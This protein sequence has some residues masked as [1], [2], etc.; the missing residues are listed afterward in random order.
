MQ[1]IL[2]IL[3][4]HFTNDARVLKEAR[5]LTKAGYKV[6]IFCLWDN[7]L[8]KEETQEDIRIR[9]I[10][11][12]PQKQSS[13]FH[14]I[15]ALIAFTFNC[16]VK[17]SFR[18]EIIHC[19]DIDALP[20]GVMIK[21]LKPGTKL[22]YDAHEYE[23]ECT[24]LKG[25]TKKI[26]QITERFFIRY[27]NSVISV[28]NSIANEYKR[29]YNIPKPYLV[30]NCPPYKDVQKQNRFR[31]KFNISKDKIVVL[32]QGGFTAH[33]GIEITL[34]AFKNLEDS[35]KVIVF[36]GYGPL[37]GLVKEAAAA[38]NNI[39]FHEAV[40]QDVLLDYT[41]SAD[42]GI[43]FYENTCLNHYYCS[44]NKFFEYTMAGLPIIV[45][46][47]YEMKSIINKYD[48]GL[49]TNNDSKSLL[50]VL[51]DLNPDDI[52]K[53]HSNTIALRKVY[54]WEE[55]EKVLLDMYNKL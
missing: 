55:Q 21:W 49:T 36:M 47:L 19:H 42:I 33:R 23:T 8:Q 12:M 18:Y 39:F 30:L 2:F 48:N 52:N 29:L 35:N 13:K 15:K 46:D 54:N 50:Q 51:K 34:E 44:P 41:A 11:Y 17:G 27:A 37:E 40:K 16:I 9:R 25:I 3:R 26:Y 20:I 14:K 45:S 7:G 53:M 22:V 28:S 24:H 4:N 1:N 43:L 32:Y 10:A 38:H 5:T 6:T 31:E